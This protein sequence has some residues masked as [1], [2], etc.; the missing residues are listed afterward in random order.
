MPHQQ[1]ALLL[2]G[3]PRH[4]NTTQHYIQYK[5]QTTTHRFHDW[6]RKLQE[7]SI[8]PAKECHVIKKSTQM[9]YKMLRPMISVSINVWGRPF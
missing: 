3:R 7:H 9:F 4:R 5:D 1:S 6:Q 2:V 8:S